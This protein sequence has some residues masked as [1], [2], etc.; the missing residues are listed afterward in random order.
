M[1]DEGTEAT[2]RP[3]IFDTDVLI[4]YFR[5]NQNARRFLQR[6]PY[7]RRVTSSLVMMELLQG[8]RDGNEVE[9]VEAFHSQ[10]I[11]TVLD[12]DGPICRRA[13][14]LL[15][16]HAA[17]DG[18]RVVDALIAATA[19]EHGCALATANVR[20]YRSIAGLTLRPFKP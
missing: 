9:E 5:A 7:R 17:S 19:I 12:P 20:H 10:N 4:W 14:T 3:L 6:V 16:R 1:D 8:C 13:V 18:L 15:K 11:A 2:I